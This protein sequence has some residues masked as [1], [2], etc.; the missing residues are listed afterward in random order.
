MTLVVVEVGLDVG[1]RAD[2]S[3]YR[4]RKY[5]DGI[6][7]RRTSA[8]A[9]E[10]GCRTMYAESESRAGGGQGQI[11]TSREL[12]P[13][14]SPRSSIDVVIVPHVSARLAADSGLLWNLEI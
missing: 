1:R 12:C 11:P 5:N 8:R 10:H 3:E 7:R 13:P 2:K 14:A 6:N 4:Q 9:G